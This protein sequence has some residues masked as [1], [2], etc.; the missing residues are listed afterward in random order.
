[1]GSVGR[2]VSGE[3]GG[4]RVDV[5]KMGG[6]DGSWEGGEDGGEGGGSMRAAQTGRMQAV[7]NVGV[8]LVV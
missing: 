5:E 2:R 3:E 8:D 6:G 4:W 7:R 1:M